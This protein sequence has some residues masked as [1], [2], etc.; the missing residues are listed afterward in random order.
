MGDANAHEMLASAQSA[1]G[2]KAASVATRA[3]YA[4]MRGESLDVSMKLATWQQE[5]GDKAAAE[6]LDSVNFIDFEN[7]T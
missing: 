1:K 4:K 3:A 5:L 6:M 7:E 2:H